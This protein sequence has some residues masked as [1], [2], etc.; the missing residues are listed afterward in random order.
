MR[1][2]TK[3]NKY[4]SRIGGGRI[5]SI[6]AIGYDVCITEEDGKQYFYRLRKYDHDVVDSIDPLKITDAV[7]IH[8]EELND[9]VRKKHFERIYPNGTEA[10]RNLFIYGEEKGGRINEENEWAEAHLVY[11]R[12]TTLRIAMELG[13]FENVEFVRSNSRWTGT[14]YKDYIYVIDGRWQVTVSANNYNT[15]TFYNSYSIEDYSKIVAQR[16]A[17][18]RRM[19][20]LSRQANV[21]WNIAVI[22]GHIESDK[23]AISILNLVK[24]AR[25]TADKDLQWELSCGIGRRTAALETILGE[26]WRKLDCSGQ[27]RTTTLANYLLGEDV[28]QFK[29]LSKTPRR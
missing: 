23:E 11:D 1:Q 29:D 15:G 18:G 13:Q 5:Y 16:K 26:N 3:E 22:A 7:D 14:G 8:W 19:K 2:I 9:N 24:K 6:W 21:P 4:D 10:D 12:E 25:G 28:Q 17:F 27:N 20:R